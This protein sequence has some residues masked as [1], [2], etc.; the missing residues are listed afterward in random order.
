[1]F[2]NQTLLL[3]IIVLVVIA[4]VAAVV[5]GVLL[6]EPDPQDTEVGA[7]AGAVED[8]NAC[9]ASNI[10]GPLKSTAPTCGA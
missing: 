1:M 6:R 8:R 3:I 4:I 9:A 5:F 10:Y 2:E 7:P